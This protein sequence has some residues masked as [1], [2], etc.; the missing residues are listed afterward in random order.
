MDFNLRFR[1]S[2]LR[3]KIILLI[4]F[5][6]WNPWSHECLRINRLLKTSWT[7]WLVKSCF[8]SNRCYLWFEFA[9]TIYTLP[10]I[11]ESKLV[12]SWTAFS[13]NFICCWS[14]FIR[15]IS[16][17]NTFSV[18][19]LCVDIWILF[20]LGCIFI[21]RNNFNVVIIIFICG[22]S[23]GFTE[24]TGWRLWSCKFFDWSKVLAVQSS[25]IVSNWNIQIC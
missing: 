3:F 13:F 9:G 2:C 11:T 7:F 16:S 19:I 10:F 18:T 8:T 22:H 1:S 23:V 17:R 14:C 20:L 24:L 12:S 5:D 15:N 6:W 4:S 21:M 25:A